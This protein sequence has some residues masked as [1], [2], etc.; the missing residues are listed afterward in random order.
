[1]EEYVTLTEL[2]VFDQKPFKKNLKSFIK[3]FKVSESDMVVL[4]AGKVGIK[5]NWIK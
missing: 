4:K 5:K 3:T 2:Y 1:M